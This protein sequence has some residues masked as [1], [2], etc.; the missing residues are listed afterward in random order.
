[1]E[2]FGKLAKPPVREVI[3]E[4]IFKDDFKWDFTYPGELFNKIKEEFPIK[5]SVIEGKIKFDLSKDLAPKDQSVSTTEIPQ[6]LTSD[7]K[8]FVVLKKNR[9][10]IHHR[11]EYT[12]WE[13]YK[14]KIDLVYTSFLNI[15]GQS[16]T[17]AG[18]ENKIAQIGLRYVN[19]VNVPVNYQVEQIFNFTIPKVDIS[20]Q[21]EGF[22][23]GNLYSYDKNILQVQLLTENGGKGENRFILDLDYFTTEFNA[24]DVLD[25]AE[26][27]HTEIK[28]VFLNTLSPKALD[29]FRE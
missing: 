10:S 14:A 21:L 17:A 15:L 16:P 1:M 27:A 18:I 28:R 13:N 23:I 5:K 9:L 8:I 20:S 12:S 25:W 19:D 2:D 24:V 6:F 22:M 26:H 11:R 3:F 7:E 4:L 29:L